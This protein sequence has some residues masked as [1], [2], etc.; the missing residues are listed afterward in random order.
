MKI[1]PLGE[2]LVLEKI[3]AEEKT[4]S[5]IIIPN[6]DKEQSNIANIVALSEDLKDKPV[7]IGDK[8]L[9]SEYRATELKD[10]DKKYLVI[11]YGDILAIIE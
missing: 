5:G 8:V 7:K 11:N 3:A 9:F 10:D 6:S 4:L 2:R 1:K